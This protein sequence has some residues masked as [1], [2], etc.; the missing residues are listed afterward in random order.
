MN[1]GV[2]LE[3]INWIEAEKWF[4]TD[5]VV[6]IPLGAAAKQHGPHLSLNN[7]AIIAG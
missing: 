1:S 2:K 5:P 3:T 4:A 7:D 6:V